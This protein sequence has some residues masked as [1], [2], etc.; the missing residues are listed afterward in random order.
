MSYED[1]IHLSRPIS[2]N[3]KPM[4]LQQRAAQ[5]SPFAALT[6]YEQSIQ[7]AH[8]LTS[9]ERELSEEQKQSLDMKQMILMEHIKENPLIDI[10]Y[11]MKDIYKEGGS[12]QTYQGYLKKIDTI[13]RTFLFLDGT[14]IPIESIVE[15][16]SDLTNHI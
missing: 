3:H 2:K 10:T 4:S 16:N 8:R 11:F 14:K 12:Y 1:I 7:E 5:F 13:I 9:N 15:I 6:G